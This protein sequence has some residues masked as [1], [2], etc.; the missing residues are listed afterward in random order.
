MAVMLGSLYGALVEAGAGHDAAQKAAEE[1]ASLRDEIARI[2]E[3]FAAM[4]NENTSL[5][6][7]IQLLKWMLGFTLAGVVAIIGIGI[8]ILGQP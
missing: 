2:R 1:G 5:R 3:E 4:R 6:G 8:R 7:D